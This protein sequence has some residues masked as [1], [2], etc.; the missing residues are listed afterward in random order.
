MDD[1]RN[2]LIYLLSAMNT[3]EVKGAPNVKTMANCMTF[4]EQMIAKHDEAQ[5]PGKK[6][7]GNKEDA[8][9]QA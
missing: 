1:L 5:K 9:E 4:V 2:N 3:I 7:E 8:K 6:P